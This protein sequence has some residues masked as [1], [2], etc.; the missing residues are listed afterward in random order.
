VKGSETR[1]ELSAM[2]D[3]SCAACDRKSNESLILRFDD[4]R[5]KTGHVL[6]G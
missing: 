3:V 2:A 6:T 5:K 4:L 1:V